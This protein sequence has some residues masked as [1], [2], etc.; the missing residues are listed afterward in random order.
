MAFPG[1]S[2]REAL[3]LSGLGL[4]G[5]GCCGWFPQFAARAAAAG[6]APQRRAVLLWMSGGP[7]QLD[8]FDMKPDHANGGEFKEI[9]TSVPGV[10]FSEHLPK[11]AK[12]A[13]KLAIVRSIKTKEGDHA[14]ATQLARTG[15]APGQDLSYPAVGCSLSKALRVERLALPQH[16]SIAS[17]RSFPAAFGP[18]FLGPRYAP[19]SV[20]GSP[21]DGDGFARLRVEN[22]DPPQGV[23]AD[24]AARREALWDALQQEFLLGHDDGALAAHDG[25]HRQALELV[26]GDAREAFDL[27]QEPDLVREA[28]GKGRFGQGCLLA[29]RLLERGVPFVEVAL[30][31]EGLGWDTHNDGFRQVRD[32]SQELDNGWG[33]LMQE[34]SERGLLDST[35]I[36]CIGEFGRTPTINNMGGRDHFPNAWSCVLA[37]GGVAGGQVYGATSPDGSEVVENPV[38]VQEVLATFCGALGVDPATENDAEL[39]RPIKIVEAEPIRELLA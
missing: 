11:L 18:G 1:I 35:T 15:Y 24:R 3:R 14:R 23:D 9:A 20:D 19:A 33:T 36:L 29:R 27:S 17:P 2:R 22:L 21:P 34:L 6:V 8:T 5:A 25:M 32:L 38:G 30:G 39:G 31:G 16:V 10:R 7:S 12:Q 4:L 26:R 37:G 28:Y 13:D